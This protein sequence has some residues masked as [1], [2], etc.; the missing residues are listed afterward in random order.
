[1]TF[2]DEGARTDQKCSPRFRKSAYSAGHAKAYD[3]C[4]GG[5]DIDVASTPVAA[6]GFFG[7]DAGEMVG[8]LQPRYI[9]IR[10]G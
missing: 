9:V 2:N 6:A 8:V 1:M 7:L 4:S 10:A 3:V 5:A